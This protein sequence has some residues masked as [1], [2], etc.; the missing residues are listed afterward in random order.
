MNLDM[1]NELVKFCKV[2][3]HFSFLQIPKVSFHK[4]DSIEQNRKTI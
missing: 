1:P 3:F 2:L 4:L